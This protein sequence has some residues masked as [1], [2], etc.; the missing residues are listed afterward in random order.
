MEGTQ[1]RLTCRLQLVYFWRLPTTPGHLEARAPKRDQWQQRRVPCHFPFR[2]NL[3]AVRLSS[4]HL[5]W[6]VS[7]TRSHRWTHCH[8]LFFHHPDKSFLMKISSSTRVPSWKNLLVFH[9]HKKNS[10]H[11]SHRGDLLNNSSR[12]LSNWRVGELNSMKWT[13]LAHV[14]KRAK[15]ANSHRLLGLD[16]STEAL[17]DQIETYFT[18]LDFSGLSGPSLRLFLFFFF[19]AQRYFEL[20]SFLGRCLS[21]NLFRLF[22]LK[23]TKQKYDTH[24]PG[25][26]CGCAFNEY[27]RPADL[28]LSSVPHCRIAVCSNP[29]SPCRGENP[30]KWLTQP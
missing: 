16:L 15:S 25:C 21:V 23:K 10:I 28:Y 1:K 12:I 6:L 11:K 3:R 13:Y 26:L 20:D 5:S 14:Q 29:L 18:A 30:P 7:A 27:I 9:F 8:K 17:S 4:P 22:F 2:I 24:S 19:A